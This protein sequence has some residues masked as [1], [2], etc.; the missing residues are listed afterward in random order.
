MTAHAHV[1]TD[2]RQALWRS[3]AVMASAGT[4][5]T[6]LLTGRLIA[7]LVRA[8]C[9][10][11][12]PR[13]A[14][15][16][17]P[18]GLASVLSATF[19][20]KAAGEVFQR[21]VG[22]LAEAAG[23]AARAQRLAEEIG[24]PV[25]PQSAARLAAVVARHADRLGV[26][27]ID[28]FLLRAAAAFGP[29]LGLPARWGL[30]DE[31]TDSAL[32]DAALTGVLQRADAAQLASLLQ[33]LS[34][35]RADR[36]P[37]ARLRAR[38]GEVYDTYL[39]AP[40]AAAWAG[41]PTVPPA[42]P[43]GLLRAAHDA[44]AAMPIPLTKAGQP[45]ASWQR[46]VRAAAQALRARQWEGFLGVTLVERALT[47][48]A[49]FDRKAIG[50]EH[51][52]AIRPAAGLAARAVLE[53][54]GHSAAALH[55]L[56]ERFHHA[57]AALKQQ[58]GLFGFDDP[59]ARLL[60]AAATGDAQELYFRLDA[61]I[62]HV[63]LDEF[64]D[65]SIDQFRLLEPLLA[66]AMA[67]LP[68][69]CDH[70][71]GPHDQRSVLAVGDRKQ[72]LYTWRRAE[73]A[74]LGS[75][76]E[77]WPQL[78]RL[79]QDTS[80]RSSPAVIGLVNAVFLNLSRARCLRR[81]D[82]SDHPI[83]PAWAGA[84]VPHAAARAGAS[85]SARVIVARSLDQG[86][87]SACSAQARPRL[88][89]LHAAADLAGRALPRAAQLGERI[90]II[91]PT[92]RHIARVLSILRDRGLPASDQAGVPITDDPVVPEA[93]SLVHLIEHP[94]DG[95]AFW[96]AAH[97]PLAQA[98]GL[99]TPTPADP[100]PAAAVARATEPLR[101]R[102]A[103]AGLARTLAWLTHHAAPH[104]SGPEARALE[105]LC[106][107]ADE[108]AQAASGPG[109]ASGAAAGGL[110]L[111]GFVQRA[112][113]H[114][115]PSPS[116]ATIRVMTIHA[117]KGLEFEH[118][119]VPVLG[120]AWEPRQPFVLRDGPLEPA[121][122]VA[123]RLPGVLR[124]IR[125]VDPATD[126]L[127]TAAELR[128]ADEALCELY[129]SLTRARSHLTVVI[130]RAPDSGAARAHPSSDRV[131][132]E[133]LGVT[134]DERTTPGRVVYAAGTPPEPQEPEP[135]PATRPLPHEPAAAGMTPDGPAPAPLRLRI[136]P[137]RREVS[138]WTT[139]SPSQIA[140]QLV[141]LAAELQ[142]RADGRRHAGTALHR[143]M[144]RVGWLSDPI[145]SD[146]ELVAHAAGLL[147][148]GPARDAVAQFRALLRG[149]CAPEV[150]DK[151]RLCNGRP[152]CDRLELRREQ[153][154]AVRRPQDPDRPLI[155]GTIDRLV[156]ARRA[157]E[158]VWADIVDFKTDRLS[159]RPGL[160][161]E[162]LALYTPQVR[163]YADAVGAL[164][165]LPPGAITARLWLTEPDRLVLIDPDGPAR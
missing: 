152:P 90:A 27:T 149:A 36:S 110:G 139:R 31:H 86:M 97:S 153:T 17:E 136:A 45:Q 65:T 156:I 99:P 157:G 54:L 105:A 102:I 29:E 161:D 120:D 32:R 140:H 145:P 108:H 118:V 48:E 124:A 92:N 111:S 33:A 141:D 159:D 128:A 88:E 2:P 52:A 16:A 130:P 46:A 61:T 66:E 69:A 5:K 115:V 94:G 164:T 79:T 1:G 98:A 112:L 84:F 123:P 57:L 137:P 155:T 114:R 132:A 131:L 93:L 146:E 35:G 125:G 67:H 101:Q 165:G 64:Q 51:L 60:A 38:L 109:G 83:V 163:A 42:D 116:P 6:F 18:R 80:H 34:G 3:A 4:G 144:E 10:T 95:T 104:L 53:R 122:A 8:G 129:V 63:L 89:C 12:P 142:P 25:T 68:P 43:E 81:P 40:D 85:G 30:L 55:T 160:L 71:Q 74:L 58:A 158:P 7:L 135:E 121:R 56:V 82:G 148:P 49:S 134:P 24:A 107:L 22:R 117:S 13:G 151:A 37:Y 143:W 87:A 26:M 28:A 126:E 113:A 50:P 39:G 14:R 133:A 162:R 103:S 75:L 41:A 77:R 62:R 47:G 59:P 91:T 138:P 96:H 150:L 19:T 11:A 76:P 73:P 119:I 78:L 9:A 106:A 147:P 44:L 15:F 70:D 21:V 20:R 72:A 127:L 100:F 154:F 23:D